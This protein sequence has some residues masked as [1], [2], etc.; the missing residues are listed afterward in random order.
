MR[1]QLKRKT[2]NRGPPNLTTSNVVKRRLEKN[3]DK[4]FF[5]IFVVSF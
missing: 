5:E 4:V 3:R 2:I 1:S